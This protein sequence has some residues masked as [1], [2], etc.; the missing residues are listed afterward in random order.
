MDVPP[1]PER[2]LEPLPLPAPEKPTAPELVPDLPTAAP[3]NKPSSTRAPRTDATKPTQTPEPPPVVEVPA[4]P[5]PPPSVPPLRLPNTAADTN[6]AARQMRDL[7]ERAKKSLES[8][9]YRPLDRGQRDQYDAAKG[10]LEQSEG[11]LK[12]RDFELAK[13]YAEKAEQIAKQLQK[14]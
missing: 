4:P 1:V 3:V 13:N 12:A 8:V 5:P 11:T 7:L 6:E 9:D 2:V 10:L 14:R